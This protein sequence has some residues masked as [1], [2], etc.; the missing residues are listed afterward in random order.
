MT[1]DT[2]AARLYAVWAADKALP[3]WE[4]LPDHRRETW[5]RI[6]AVALEATTLT[7]PTA[8]IIKIDRRNSA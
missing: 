5:R 7:A 4:R 6:A 1:L 2:L 8:R 3:A